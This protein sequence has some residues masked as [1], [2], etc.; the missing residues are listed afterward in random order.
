MNIVVNG[1]QT[2]TDEMRANASSYLH[3]WANRSAEQG[4]ALCIIALLDALD[5]LE[6]TKESQAILKDIVLNG[7]EDEIAGNVNHDW[8]SDDS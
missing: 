4:M 3:P 7:W 6:K 8:E 1:N 5:E 2:T